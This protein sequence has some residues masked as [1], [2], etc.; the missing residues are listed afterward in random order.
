M[1]KFDAIVIGFGKAGKTLAADLSKQGQKVLLV[2]KS[3]AYYGGTCINIGC[4][5]TKR[6]L[7]EAK[8]R[9]QEADKALYYQAAKE[10]QLA[11]KK[12]MNQANYNR[13][14]QS[15]VELLEG[16][17]RFVDAHTVEVLGEHYQADLIFINT[18]A[19]PFLPKIE[20]L[21][22][23]ERVLTSEGLLALTELP[24]KLSILGGGFISLEFATMFRQFGTEVD[25]FEAN[26]KFLANEDEDVSLAI[27]KSLEEQGIK[28][29]LGVKIERIQESAEEVRLEGV[30]AE[31]QSFS[32]ASDR[33][34]V[35]TGRKANVEGLDVE[36]AGVALTE[37]GAVQVNEFLQTSQPHIYA[38]GDVNG[39]KQFTY[40]SLDDYRIVK[41]HLAGDTSYSLKDRAEVP[42]SVFLTPVF[43]RIGLTEKELKAQGIPYRSAEL[44]IA[45][46]PKAKIL[47]QNTGFYKVMVHAETEEILGAVLFAPDSH[48]VVNLFTLA[49]SQKL[50]YKVFSRQIFTH[51]SMAESLNDLFALLG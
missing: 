36:K 40:I 41:A 44:G 31:G 22:L 17:A 35:A 1:K 9:P 51:P 28:I 50:S 12:A 6:L 18:G 10:R 38:L 42:F 20:S 45:M 27:Q 46:M 47:A 29:H 11:L 4:I 30:N 19:T 34:L 3:A 33:L 16:A 23:S 13:V 5:P 39:G 14:T 7:E 25:V 49:M 8:K 37:R 21:T 32:H 48:E 26:A 24:Q 15:G 2:E 43:S